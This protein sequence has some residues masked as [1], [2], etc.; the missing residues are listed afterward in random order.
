MRG[1]MERRT[2]YGSEVFTGKLKK[3]YEI[4][5][6]IRPLGRPRRELK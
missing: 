4:E 3:A 5:E 1:E 2:I 6:I